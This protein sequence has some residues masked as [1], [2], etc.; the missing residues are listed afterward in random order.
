MG[1]DKS[2]K[3][4]SGGVSTDW[5]GWEYD[6]NTRR[7]VNSRIN[8]RGVR[9][10]D[11]SEECD[12]P[13]A[14]TEDLAG[15]IGQINISSGEPRPDRGEDVAQ[16]EAIPSPLSGNETASLQVSPITYSTSSGSVP[17]YQGRDFTYMTTGQSGSAMP[18]SL[19]GMTPV[20]GLG[21]ANVSWNDGQQYSAGLSGSLPGTNPPNAVFG[22]QAQT[23]TANDLSPTQG[24]GGK[25]TRQNTSRPDDLLSNTDQS[26]KSTN[27]RRLSRVVFK[28]V[29]TEPHGNS[30]GQNRRK[31]SNRT[32]ISNT[33]HG[34]LSYTSIRR[35]AIIKA[36]QGHS[37]CLPI[38]TYGGKGTKKPGVKPHHHAIIY[39]PN[40]SGGPTGSPG[41]LEDEAP[42]VN[43]PIRVQLNSARH[44]F[45]RA[46]RINYAKVYTVEHNIKVCFVGKIHKKSIQDFL[47]TYAMVDEMADDTIHP[48]NT[49]YEY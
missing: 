41:E 4:R 22:N 18:N 24:D 27:R 30:N 36:R 12:P 46:S 33:K 1:R 47:D 21:R 38:L 13:V 37:L 9:V 43:V 39:T 34:E 5:A 25:I 35:F 44:Q 7:Y 6:N 8:S 15:H 19:G 48:E 28:V 23:R 26:L 31:P 10:Y 40:P 3:S 20:I 49:V 16:R 32:Y 42:L 14:P 11:Y 29:W 17:N 2:K 45:D